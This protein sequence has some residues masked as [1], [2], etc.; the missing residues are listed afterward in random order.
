[1]PHKLFQGRW[2]PGPDAA[3]VALLKKKQYAAVIVWRSMLRDA[4]C[5][6]GRETSRSLAEIGAE[7][8]LS[9]N[10]IIR[11]QRQLLKAGYMIRRSGG[12]KTR[13]RSV[14]T[15]RV[16]ES[17]GTAN[18]RQEKQPVGDWEL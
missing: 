9:E 14:W 2:T 17:Y 12:G 5:R 13:R 18:I 10:T 7:T 16:P 15:M 11:A 3:E 4:L 8:R 6:P 1:M